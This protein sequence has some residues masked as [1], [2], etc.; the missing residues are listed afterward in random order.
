[1][2]GAFQSPDFLG[3]CHDAFEGVAHGPSSEKAWQEHQGE[4]GESLVTEGNAAYLVKGPEDAAVG[5]VQVWHQ[6]GHQRNECFQVDLLLE[7]QV[8]S[9]GDHR[10]ED[11]HQG[12]DLQVDSRVELLSDQWADQEVRR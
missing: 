4:R 2:E 8:D 1:M 7:H 5:L 12:M 11:L 3:N 9:Q 10:Q 6:A